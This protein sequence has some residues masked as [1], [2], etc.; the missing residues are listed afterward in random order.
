[1]MTAAWFSAKV[2]LV[3]LI[4]GSDAVEYRDS[5]FVFRSTDF[6]PAFQRALAI[7]RS[8]EEQ[9][10]NAE[11]R[12]VRWRFKEIV[13]LDIIQTDELDGAEVYSEPVDL[14][15]GAKIEFETSFEP[16]LSK[17]TQTI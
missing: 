12:L 3:L 11:G 4:A 16:E 17:P 13:S 9:Y 2:R 15:E 14:E 8:Q 1:M 5:I 6:P 7:G 10:E